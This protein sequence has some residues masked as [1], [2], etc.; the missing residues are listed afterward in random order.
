MWLAALFACQRDDVMVKLTSPLSVDVHFNVG[1]F[2]WPP[3]KVFPV[4]AALDLALRTLLT[5][6]LLFATLESFGF[7]RHAA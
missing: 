2:E 4:A 7:T 5:S 3:F 6:G 1:L